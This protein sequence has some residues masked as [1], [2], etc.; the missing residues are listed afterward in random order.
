MAAA[1][2]CQAREGAETKKKEHLLTTVNQGTG[3]G[4]EEQNGKAKQV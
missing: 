1:G 4:S 2:P 3:D